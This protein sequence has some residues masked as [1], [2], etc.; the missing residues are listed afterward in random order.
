[1][2]SIKSSIAIIAVSVCILNLIYFQLKNAPVR[3]QIKALENRGQLLDSLSKL[4]KKS[5]NQ[6]KQQEIYADS[7]QQSLTTFKIQKK[8]LEKQ[9]AKQKYAIDTISN[10]E[11]YQFFTNFEAITPTN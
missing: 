1:M 10:V 9:K 2:K 3:E 5:Q 6:L 11:L 7:I 4:N 8:V